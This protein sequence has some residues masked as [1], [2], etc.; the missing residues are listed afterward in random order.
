MYYII[1][2][3]ALKSIYND[4]QEC[5]NDTYHY[6]KVEVHNIEISIWLYVTYTCNEMIININ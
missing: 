2:N 1:K 6:F 4:E 3:Y 5:I